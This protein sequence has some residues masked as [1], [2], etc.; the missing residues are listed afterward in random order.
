LIAITGKSRDL[1]I[2]ALNAAF[3]DANR[4]YEYLIVGI[5]NIN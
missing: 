5:P 1:V 4:A 3:G 2:K